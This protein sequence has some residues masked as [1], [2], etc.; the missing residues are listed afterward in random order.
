MRSRRCAR[1]HV[2][3]QVL[4]PEEIAG[5]APGIG[6][7]LPKSAPGFTRP[8]RNHASW[9]GYSLL[10]GME[11][12]QGAP[13]PGLRGTENAPCLP[14]TL[15]WRKASTHGSSMLRMPSSTKVRRLGG[16][17]GALRPCRTCQPRLLS[18][19]RRARHGGDP[20]LSRAAATRSLCR[21]GGESLGPQLHRFSPRTPGTPSAT[22]N[23]S[24]TRRPRPFTD[25]LAGRLR[26][27]LAH[28]PACGHPCPYGA[29]GT[30]CL[31][32][33]CD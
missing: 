1:F 22:L 18:T 17:G 11:L 28:L 33:A 29:T 32:G 7:I 2:S 25:A 13:C 20:R 10:R 27:P 5:L 12:Y 31:Q 8:R 21:P 3:R 14:V 4:C 23:P 16:S 15:E 24:R 30:G 6:Q 19:L 26:S 9:C